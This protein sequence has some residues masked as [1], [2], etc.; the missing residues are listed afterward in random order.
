[1]LYADRDD[2]RI[3][4]D[5]KT[6]RLIVLAPAD[7]HA[8]IRRHIAT[9]GGSNPGRPGSGLPSADTAVMPAVEIPSEEFVPL[10]HARPDRVD[11]MLRDLFGSRLKPKKSPSIPRDTGPWD[12]SKER[13]YSFVDSSRNEAELTIDQRRN[14]VLITAAGPLK[15]QL[16]R[17]I[18]LLDSP[19]Q[20]PGET[21]RIVPLRHAD[22]DKVRQAVEAYRSGYRE[23]LR[24]RPAPTSP[25]PTSPEPQGAG[26]HFHDDMVRPAAHLLQ[27]TPGDNGI[28]VTGGQPP[29]IA[30][31]EGTE[32]IELRLRQ[33]G[34]DLQIEVLPDLD[35]IIL[36]GPDRD[37]EEVSRIIE[38][39]E[40]LSV[41]T[42][43]VILVVELQHVGSEALAGVIA[44]TSEELVG[45]RQGRISVTPLVKPNALLLIGW[46]EAV[47]SIR[48]LIRKLDQPVAPETQFRVFSLRHA[49]A[50]NVLT[51]VQGMFAGRGGLGPQ[52]SVSL[53]ARS[54]SLIVQAPPRDMAE[55]AKLIEKLDRVDAETFTRATVFRLE[56]SLAMDLGAVL[57]AAIDAARGGAG[58]GRSAALELLT[59]NAEGEQLLRSG[60]LNEVQITPN[61]RN[62]TLIVA[63]PPESMEL[64]AELIRQLDTPSAVAQIKVFRIINGDANDM[65]TMLRTLLP[66][67]SATSGGPQL[68]TA[69][70]ETSLVPVRFSVDTRTNSIVATGS[71]GDLKIIEAL[72]LRLDEEDS[73]QRRNTVFRLKNAPA[74]DVAQAISN[75]LRSERIVQLAGPGSASPF[76][77]IEREVVVVP[78]VISNSLILSAT[79]R[80]FDE[81][82]ELIEKL[83]A[84]PQQVMIQVLIA[85]VALG[86][87]DEFGVELG[88]QDSLLFD[89]GLL[90]DIVT[91]VST[92]QGSTPAGIIT[93]TQEII[94]AATNTPGYNFN[95]VSTGNSGADKALRNS[96]T[97]GSQGLSSFAVGRVN[98][99]L[100]WGGLVFSAS[101]E[102]VSVLIRALQECRRLKILSRPQ[103]MTLDN[104]PAFIQVGKR[105]PRITGSTINET[106]QVNTIALEN[107]GL[108]LGVLPRISPDGL[109][110]M[111][112]DAE[113]SELGP[114][115]EGIPV[116]ISEGQIIRSPS[117]NLTMAQTTVS[118]A[119]GETIVLGGL[120]TKSTSTT[121]RRVPYLA[122]IPLLGDLFRYESKKEIRTELLI[123]LTPHIISNRED[124]ERI[125]QDEADRM[126]WC[127][128]DVNS[129]QGETGIREHRY[130]DFDAPTPVIYPDSNPRGVLIEE[131]EIQ[132]PHRAQPPLPGTP[133]PKTTGPTGPSPGYPVLRNSPFENRP[134]HVPFPQPPAAPAMG[135]PGEVRPTGYSTG[136]YSPSATRLPYAGPEPSPNPAPQ[137]PPWQR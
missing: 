32:E 98:S 13:T 72:L 103:I 55:I 80:F 108:I 99:E 14:G 20:P 101:S 120:I 22:P 123:I 110:V 125:K 82:M 63:G 93:S 27:V 116:S 133:F 41:E 56:N 12:T 129:M 46:G 113:K 8:V 90:G 106:G 1:M 65:V 104:Q 107:V 19:R 44:Q 73:Q 61:P 68:A 59:V 112:L 53:D 100:G 119:D 111:E 75:F 3:A 94:Q 35:V 74:R 91:T 126:H 11:R 122:D 127:L 50:G 85:E 97:V 130:P 28:P 42:E 54:N 87:F 51:T 134:L 70:G 31:P 66:A 37:V 83:D 16:V 69:E 115:S 76:Q 60:I 18:R 40:R 121:E 2:V 64:I 89:R 128:A 26:R 132:G 49:P 34:S 25:G 5:S 45:G 10:A 7:I 136:V 62:N 131:F 67:P 36:Q 92:T 30:G 39:L 52:A 102:S 77:Q 47:N 88:L 109:V 71:E 23:G 117:V 95:S 17:L 48:Q 15:I 96:G 84:Q 33:L 137:P 6:S 9:L 79:P 135:N 78:E 124:V 86:D 114:E 21:V 43:P 24:A 105:V 81:I 58:G 4:P 118:A 38:E 57:Q 29:A